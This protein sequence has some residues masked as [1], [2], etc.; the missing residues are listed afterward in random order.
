MMKVM[1]PN[2]LLS[3]DPYG[4]FLDFLIRASYLHWVENLVL[5]T[6][7]R[8]NE[9]QSTTLR[10]SEGNSASVMMEI[11]SPTVGT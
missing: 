5:L 7:S 4:I 11:V 8:Q 6:Y 2:D 10:C 1:K 9:H 3:T